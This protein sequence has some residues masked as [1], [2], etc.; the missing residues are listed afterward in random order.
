MGIHPGDPFAP[1]SPFAVLANDRYAA[2]VWDDEA[3]ADHIWAV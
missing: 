3:G 1:W 2:K